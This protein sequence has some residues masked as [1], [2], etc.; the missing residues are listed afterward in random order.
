MLTIAR[1][2][3][4]PTLKLRA[5]PRNTTANRTPTTIFRLITGITRT[6]GPLSSARKTP[7][8]PR[9]AKTPATKPSL[10]ASPLIS[11]LPPT[12]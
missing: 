5:S 6:S 2:M 3:P 7:S 9:A 12:R 1:T 10:K 4:R 8:V 11:N